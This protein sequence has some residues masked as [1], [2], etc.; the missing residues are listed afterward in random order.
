M[1]NTKEIIQTRGKYNQYGKFSDYKLLI[2]VTSI[3]GH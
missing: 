1:D 2:L 3:L